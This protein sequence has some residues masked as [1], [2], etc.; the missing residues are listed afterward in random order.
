M[1][2]LQNNNCNKIKKGH[3]LP[4]FYFFVESAG[5]LFVSHHLNAHSLS[6]FDLGRLTL[7]DCTRPTWP[8]IK[9]CPSFGAGLLP[10]YA[11]R[12]SNSQ[13]HTG[14][15]SNSQCH[16]IC[17]VLRQGQVCFLVIHPESQTRFHSPEYLPRPDFDLALASQTRFCITESA[18]KYVVL[19]P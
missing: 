5:D 7:S 13:C 17:Y 11:S 9:V 14:T 1:Q 19:E 6:S 3:L 12:I 16:L 8:T 18:G 15:V 2:M 4:L 10:C